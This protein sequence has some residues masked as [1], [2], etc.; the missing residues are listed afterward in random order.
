VQVFHKKWL[1]PTPCALQERRG[2][3]PRLWALWRP[4]SSVHG[5]KMPKQKFGWN[6]GGEAI[7]LS[8]PAWMATGPQA[9]LM[10]R[11]TSWR[12]VLSV[13]HDA[14]TSLTVT[15]SGSVRPSTRCHLSVKTSTSFA[16]LIAACLCAHK[17]GIPLVI[18]ATGLHQGTAC[19]SR[20]LGMRPNAL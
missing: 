6:M 19:A 1:I 16:V 12:P 2:P 15:G 18:V 8:G 7:E 17:R 3:P 4:G 10:A 13:F 20:E 11:Y 9:H 5:H 14:P